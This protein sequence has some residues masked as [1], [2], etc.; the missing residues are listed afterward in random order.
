MKRLIDVTC[1]LAKLELPFRG[2]NEHSE[3]IN[4]GNYMEFLH[5]L[6]K[7]IKLDIHL[8]STKIFKGTSCRIQ[9]DIIESISDVTLDIIKEEVKKMHLLLL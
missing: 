6:S 3:S 7:Y 8:Q 2:R 4:R 5:V 9:N 1:L